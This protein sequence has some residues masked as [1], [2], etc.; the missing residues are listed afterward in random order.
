MFIEGMSSF[1]KIFS[2]NSKF[3][4]FNEGA[5]APAALAFRRPA[6]FL[7]FEAKPKKCRTLQS[8]HLSHYVVQTWRMTNCAQLNKFRN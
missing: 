4:K 8:V 7:L 5:W 3:E 2:I 1:S 6:F